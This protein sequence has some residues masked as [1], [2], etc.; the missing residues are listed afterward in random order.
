M[1]ARVWGLVA[2]L[3]ALAGCSTVSL[4]VSV[5]IGH[6][7]GVGVRVGADG[8][9]G[10]GVGVSVGA[11]SVHVGTSGQLPVNKADDTSDQK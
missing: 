2:L 5:P 9:V 6:G 4:G 10:V 3:W 7:A 1:T 11:G 8:Q